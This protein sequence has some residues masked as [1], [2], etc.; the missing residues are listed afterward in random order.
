MLYYYDRK[1]FERPEEKDEYLAKNSILA[2]YTSN[3]VINRVF[4][5]NK[6]Q[7][8][9]A[10]PGDAESNNKIREALKRTHNLV[11][12]ETFKGDFAV[13]HYRKKEEN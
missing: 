5:M 12:E 4:R 6:F 1:A 10:N 11:K 3:E 8:V 13:L 9:V 2:Y 7:W